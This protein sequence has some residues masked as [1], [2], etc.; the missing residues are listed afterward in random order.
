M[1]AAP[2]AN[3]G[4]LQ[5]ELIRHLQGRI[6]SGELTERSLARLTGISQPHLHHVL[7]GKRLLSFEKA[8]RILLHLELDLRLLIEYAEKK[9][10]SD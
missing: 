3:F 6:Q 4:N 8:D 2:V 7:K 5:K 9:E 1:A 10:A